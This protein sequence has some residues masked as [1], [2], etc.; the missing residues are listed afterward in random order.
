MAS[1]PGSR[2][3]RLIQTHEFALGQ[4]IHFISEIIDPGGPQLIEDCLDELAVGLRCPPSLD[5]PA[6][7]FPGVEV[8]PVF[9][10]PRTGTFRGVWLRWRKPPM[11]LS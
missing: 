7:G 9:G 11:S 10:S 8:L 1:G 6:G 2:H 4:L 5:R 3:S